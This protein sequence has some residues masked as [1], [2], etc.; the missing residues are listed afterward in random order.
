MSGIRPALEYLLACSDVSLESFRISRM[1]QAA[2]LRKQIRALVDE[3]VEAEIDAGVSRC[4]LE[5]RRTEAAFPLLELDYSWQNRSLEDVTISFRPG[6]VE[7]SAIAANQKRLSTGLG[8]IEDI[9]ACLLMED[10]TLMPGQCKN[11][12]HANTKRLRKLYAKPIA[13]KRLTSVPEGAGP[14]AM[15][16][17]PSPKGQQK[18]GFEEPLV[19]RVGANQTPEP[20]AAHAPVEGCPSAPEKALHQ[21]SCNHA[22]AHGC[23]LTR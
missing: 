9:G 5:C 22:E 17:R 13:R 6:P 23:E 2:N 8:E 4:M 15:P 18:L 1:S 3:W 20:G 21:A 12:S 16:V 11:A 14:V 10:G 7:A 19:S